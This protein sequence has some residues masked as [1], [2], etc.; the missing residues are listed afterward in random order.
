MFG[1]REK[2]ECTKRDVIYNI[3]ILILICIIGFCAF[4]IGKIYWGYHQGTVVYEELAKDV[5]IH[6]KKYEIDWDKL[7]K[8]NKDVKAWMYCND[9]VINYPI[10][11]TGNNDDYLR[12]L[13]N[14]KWNVKGTPF[15]DYRC[16]DPFKRF[17][18]VIY[19]H[20]INDNTMFQPFTEYISDEDFYKKHPKLNILTPEQN[21]KVEIFSVAKLND[22]SELY[23][24]DFNSE[25]EKEQYIG[26]VMKLNQ[27]PD[28]SVGQV[29]VGV[30]DNIVMFS[31][32]TNV[33][34]EERVAV[35]GK[36][37]PTSK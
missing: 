31:T 14:G 17:N 3:I 9:T 6:G 4:N 22:D 15:I 19:G 5:G 21:Y 26:K 23:K 28:S 8:K 30:N 33:R 32:C 11:Q 12:R 13:L 18:T 7:L 35:W 27:I 2:K 36:L 34:D 25:A 20:N 29:Q 24:F 16:K 37:V 1:K 10:V